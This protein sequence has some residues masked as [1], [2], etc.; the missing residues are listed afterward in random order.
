MVVDGLLVELNKVKLCT[1]LIGVLQMPVLGLALLCMKSS[2]TP[3][4]Q[5]TLLCA[6]GLFG[7]AAAND[8]GGIHACCIVHMDE[9]Q[10]FFM[11]YFFCLIRLHCSREA[12][13][14]S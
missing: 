12:N 6:L 10:L 11:S 1:G 13:Q 7:G 5:V 2:Q 8:E 9:L 3:S 4:T 14:T